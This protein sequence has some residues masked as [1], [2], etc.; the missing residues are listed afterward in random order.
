V[1]VGFP[2]ERRGRRDGDQYGMHAK[3]GSE[4]GTIRASAA[5]D[6]EKR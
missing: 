5:R 1:C 6:E 3:T 4:T 2:S